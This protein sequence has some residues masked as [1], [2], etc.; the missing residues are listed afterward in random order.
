MR[1]LLIGST[2]VIGREAVPA[3]LAAGHEVTGLARN[4][5]RADAVRALGI[6][7]VVADLFDVDSLAGALR[8]KDA[9]VN[10]ASRI[11]TGIG[12]LTKRGWAAHDRVREQGSA[13]L[14]AAALRTDDVGVLVQEGISFVYADGG[15]AELD[16]TAPI[17]PYGPLLSSVAAHRNI[18]RFADAGRTGVRLRIAA[19]QGDDVI[20]RMLVGTAKLRLPVL[21]GPA[22]AWFTAIHPADA[23]GGAAAALGAPSGVYNLG[24]APLRKSEFCRVLAEAAGVGRVRLL[25]NSFGLGPLATFRRS[26]RVVSR[27]LTEATGWHPKH[28]TPTPDWY[29][30]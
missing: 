27:K 18:E 14:V 13:A 30:P 3:L 1:V 28:P 15:D 8:G 7:P 10:V 4:A 12:A 5:E 16:E 6:E 19:L 17:Q 9:V 26:H 22:D 21:P 29:R 23:G 25:P 2:G 20:T 24:A 11:P